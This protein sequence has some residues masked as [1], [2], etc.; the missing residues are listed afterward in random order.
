MIVA[1]GFLAAGAG[2]LL[3]KR[4]ASKGEDY[5]DGSPKDVTVGEQPKGTPEESTEGDNVEA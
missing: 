4:P 3:W 1:T 5:K 2:Y